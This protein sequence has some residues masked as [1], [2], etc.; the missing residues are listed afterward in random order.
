[1][2]NA[3]GA[4]RGREGLAAFTRDTDNSSIITVP[5]P[6]V[7]L[8]I[9]LP[10]SPVIMTKSEDARVF[11]DRSATGGRSPATSRIEAMLARVG[12]GLFALALMAMFHAAQ[13]PASA[14]LGRPAL[15]PAASAH[16]E[17]QS[18]TRVHPVRIVETIRRMSRAHALRTTDTQFI[19]SAGSPAISA[20]LIAITPLMAPQDRM[21]ETRGAGA[22]VRAPPST[23]HIL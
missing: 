12:L 10:K 3:G 18:A 5:I 23:A 6:G 22:S 7:M 8:R 17:S 4:L 19:A 20:E 21:I 13:T 15:V 14:G 9:C 1:M 2:V 16:I 11:L